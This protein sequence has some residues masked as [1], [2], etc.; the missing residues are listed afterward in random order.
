MFYHFSIKDFARLNYV[1]LLFVNVVLF[2]FQLDVFTALHLEQAR[3]LAKAARDDAEDVPGAILVALC[4]L[5]LLF[6]KDVDSDL[7]PGFRLRCRS[8]TF[9]LLELGLYELRRPEEVE[10]RH[11]N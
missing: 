9:S 4:C 11:L 8:G 7:F 10:V 1:P 2:P 5:I 6:K 3:Q